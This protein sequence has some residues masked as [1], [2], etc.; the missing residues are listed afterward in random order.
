MQFIK[1]TI[2]NAS[3]PSN[4]YLQ[5]AFQ[6]CWPIINDLLDDDV[7]VLLLLQLEAKLPTLVAYVQPNLDTR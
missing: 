3:Y 1:Q 6:V 7:P 4:Y 2:K 5:A